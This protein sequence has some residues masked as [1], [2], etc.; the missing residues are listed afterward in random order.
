MRASLGASRLLAL[1][2]VGAAASPACSKAPSEPTKPPTPA[3]EPGPPGPG[4]PPADRAELTAAQCESQ[5]GVV[6]GDIGD[7]AIHQ[8][9]Y[10]CAETGAPPIGTIVPDPDVDGPI[11]VEGAVCCA[12]D[13]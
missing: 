1:T 10:T 9:G 6:V 4:E 2:L 11:A 5:G 8:P 12:A 3:E 7:G 13:L